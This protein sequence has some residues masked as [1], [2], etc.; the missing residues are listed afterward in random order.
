MSPYDYFLSGPTGLTWRAPL[1]GLG[2]VLISGDSE[3][4]AEV[5]AH[6][7]LVGGKA[8]QALRAT[9]GE[10][11]LIVSWG[12]SHRQRRRL[13]QQALRAFPA[14]ELVA[15]ITRQEVERQVAGRPFSLHDVGHRASLRIVLQGLLG[16]LDDHEEAPLLCSAERFQHSFSSP[17][18][19]FVPWLRRDLGPWSPWGRLLRRR[20]EL[21]R[22]LVARRPRGDCMAARLQPH[23]EPASY[24]EELLALLMFG[25]ETTAGSLSWCLAHALQRPQDANRIG[26][27]DEEFTLAFVQE[28]LRVSPPVAQLTRVATGPLRLG[29]WEVAEG[30]VVM[31][32]IP[33]AHQSL[34]KGFD[35]ER[36]LGPPPSPTAYC[37][38][39]F[40]SRLC[41]GRAVA[42]RQLTVMLRT[43]LCDY[44]WRAV[45]VGTRP[46]RH[47]FLVL[48]RGGV[49]VERMR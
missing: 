6:P 49:V 42:L 23:L 40:G 21:R 45:D 32:A 12:S 24:A 29:D 43:L 16:P 10:D 22:L 36:F 1:P 17:L 5:M 31:P 25:H 2:T 46:C 20:E 28:C 34:G 33:L 4:L 44:R 7:D 47:L 9:L 35:P 41:P 38:F 15:S 14:D 39:G 19:L 37:P 8:H 13:V 48:P 26:Q 11:H 3:L 18:L 27:G 30:E